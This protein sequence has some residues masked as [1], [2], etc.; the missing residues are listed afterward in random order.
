MMAGGSFVLLSAALLV[1]LLAAAET[2]GKTLAMSS[3]VCG[4]HVGLQS[5]IANLIF[6]LGFLWRYA[7]NIALWPIF[8]QDKEWF[9]WEGI[10]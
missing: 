2:V 9:Y 3:V 4:V 1:A 10:L 8:N 5:P 6:A 7:I